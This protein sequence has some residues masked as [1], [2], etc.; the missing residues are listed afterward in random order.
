MSIEEVNEVVAIFGHE[1]RRAVGSERRA[2][3]TSSLF[4]VPRRSSL[5][6][7][8][9]YEEGPALL[10]RLLE[11]TTPEALGEAMKRP[12]SRPYALSLWVVLGMY[13]AGRQQVCLDQGVPAG[14]SIDE[15]RYEDLRTVVDFYTRISGAYRNDDQLFPTPAVPTQPVLGEQQLARSL[16]VA[17]EPTA[18]R[19]A[20]MRK[21]GANLTLHSFLLHGEQR[22]GLFSHGPYPGPDGSVVWFEEFNDL[23]N[24]ILPWAQL[25][26]EEIPVD[27]VVY[28]YAADGVELEA[29]MFGALWV[30]PLDYESSLRLLGA[31]TYADDAPR[32]IEDAELETIAT[33][34]ASRYALIF[35][36]AVAWS[37][38]FRIAYGAPL[39]ANHLIP[40]F[41]LAGVPDGARLVFDTFERA[42][43]AAMA[44]LRPDA[45][46]P[47][48]WTH[49][50][51]DASR[52][53]Y[54]PVR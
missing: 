10:R 36:Q 3:L 49:L 18:E 8:I 35:E 45:E 25:D 34:A 50:A 17:E 14:E 48:F 13:L 33:V 16:E 20:A 5:A 27:N 19:L 40:F 21:A 9:F 2:N 46:V 47:S 38:E 43:P 23:R 42:T 15:P 41:E 32:R 53:L 11:R 1:H 52:P 7:R 24:E 6:N 12:G 31:F 28:V 51:S 30:S 44:G 39:F 26:C 22:D 54:S 4:D 37:D 29:N